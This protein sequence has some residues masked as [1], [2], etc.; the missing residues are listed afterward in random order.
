M[1]PQGWVLQGVCT[2]HKDPDLWFEEEDLTRIEEAK[3]ICRSC[4]VRML[5]EN[6]AVDNGETHGIWGGKNFNYMGKAVPVR[7]DSNME[8]LSNL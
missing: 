3:S 7:K 6:A 1:V 5:C 8:V 2:T 4:P